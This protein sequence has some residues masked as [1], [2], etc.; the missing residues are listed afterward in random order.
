MTAFGDAVRKHELVVDLLSRCTFPK[1][2]NAVDCAVSGGADSV[3]LLVLAVAS[4]C[5]ATAWHVDH[6]L[7]PDGAREAALVQALT[8]R[9]GCGFELRHVTVDDS[10]NVEARARDARFAVL[11]H[12]VMTGHTADDQAE[13]MLVNLIRGAGSRG[14]AAMTPSTSK[15]ILALR[16]SE[17]HALCSALGLEVVVDP[18]N[19]SPAFQRNRIRNE[20]MPLLADIAA[21]DVVAVLTRQAD[22][23]RDDDALLD[24][25]ARALDP[26]DAKALSSAPRALARR[27]VRLWLSDRY[28]PDVATVD[29]VLG[30]AAGEATACDIEGAR[31]VRRSQQRLILEDIDPQKS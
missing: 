15:P 3:A 10:A 1:P 12:G 16:R 19:D 2:G 28:P 18:T 13:T 11:P 25:L 20:V 5:E 14:L 26:T 27:A 31:R 24:E 7:R 30:V 22:L 23:L 8:E 4:G 29:R 9:L 21:R 6:H 17:T